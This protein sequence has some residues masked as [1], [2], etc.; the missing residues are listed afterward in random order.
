MT[1]IYLGTL[2]TESTFCEFAVGLAR[3]AYLGVGALDDRIWD[4]PTNE[5]KK[6]RAL[7]IVVDREARYS[8]K[9]YDSKNHPPLS[10][11]SP[12]WGRIRVLS[13]PQDKG[14]PIALLLGTSQ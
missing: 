6:A 2:S 1:G 4:W 10:P 8:Q 13:L 9:N 11:F 7:H 3:R 5:I 12:I 14:E